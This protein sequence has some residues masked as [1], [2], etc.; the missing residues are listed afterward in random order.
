MA[1]PRW[2]PITSLLLS[3]VGLAGSIY[4]SITHFRTVT[5]VVLMCPDLGSCNTI[6]SSNQSHFL[7]IPV[8]LLGLA[9]F[10]PMTVLCLPVAWRAADRRIHLARLI[11]SILGIGMI[12]YLFIEELFILKALCTWCTVVHV[13][14]FLLFVIIL[15][16]SPMVLARGRGTEVADAR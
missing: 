16:T 8:P 10:V 6:L 2:Q 11:L 12:L 3:L 5:G 7:G 14:G 9:Y 4:L 1:T 13:V 15:A